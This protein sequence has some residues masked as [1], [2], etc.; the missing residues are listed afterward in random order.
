MRYQAVRWAHDLVDEPVMLFSEID[1]D[2]YE[3]RKVDEYR[4]GR[5]DLADAVTETGSTALGRGSGVAAGRDQSGPRVRRT[6][7]HQ[8]GVRGGVASGLEER[9]Q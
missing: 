8:R 9:A 6:F 5:L 3:V 1:A 7:H 4:N 2:G